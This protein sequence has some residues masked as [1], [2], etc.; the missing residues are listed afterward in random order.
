MRVLTV[1]ALVCVAAPL[2]AQPDP[3]P[4]SAY[5]PLDVGN[6]WEYEVTID[7]AGLPLAPIVY[8]DSLVADS[9]VGG[10]RYIVQQRI[11]IDLE[12]GLIYAEPLED[13]LLRFDSDAATVM[14][15]MES[16]TEIP[17]LTPCPFD[18]PIDAAPLDCGDNAVFD[19]GR[20]ATTVNIGP[21]DAPTDV[22]TT[23]LKSFTWNDTD[24]LSLAAGLGIARERR[25]EDDCRLRTLRYARIGTRTYGVPRVPTLIVLPDSN[26]PTDYYPLAIGHAWEYRGNILSDP[27][28]RIEIRRD[29]VIE[30]TRHFVQEKWL[31]EPGSEEPSYTTLLIPTDNIPR[32]ATCLEAPLYLLVDQFGSTPA[33]AVCAQ[34]MPMNPTRDLYVA[35]QGVVLGKETITKVFGNLGGASYYAAGLGDLAFFGD[36]AGSG[37]S[38]RYARIDGE[39]FGTATLEYLIGVSAEDTVQPTKFK[40]TAYPNPIA[41][42][43]TLR[44]AMPTPARVTVEVYDVL[45]RLVSGSTIGPRSTNDTF[46]IETGTWASGFYLVR[47]QTESGHTE[48]VRL[49]KR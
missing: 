19:V 2:W 35:R 47:V 15:R 13:M 45:G 17:Y 20:K 11:R 27:E 9:L 36:P 8:R 22:I 39:E 38:L 32:R 18:S 21:R 14:R 43:T 6:T 5:F 7:Q 30:G 4:P 46:V 23:T 31:L 3:N 41:G 29:T 26:S 10:T 48:T 33:E 37:Y 44:I 40:I 12:G 24:S 16:G 25:C 42:Q 28:F 49:T 1:V 34:D